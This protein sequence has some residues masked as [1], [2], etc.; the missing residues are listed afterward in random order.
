MWHLTVFFFSG[1]QVDNHSDL[2]QEVKQKKKTGFQKKCE[3][4]V[5]LCIFLLFTFFFV[6][7]LLASLG[8][9]SA[10]KKKRNYSFYM[11]L[12]L[13]SSLLTLFDFFFFRPCVLIAVVVV[14]FFVVVS[15]IIIIIKGALFFYCPFAP[16]PPPPLYKICG[17]AALTPSLFI[18]AGLLFF[19]F[20]FSIT[21]KVW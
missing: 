1:L 8:Y 15:F 13:I 19:S 5:Y 6:R 2:L 7:L 14:F 10:E 3:T 9:L 11:V 21:L 17:D 12:K 20:F 18:E 4:Y 16:H